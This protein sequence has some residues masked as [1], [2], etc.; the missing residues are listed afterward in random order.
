[1]GNSLPSSRVFPARIGAFRVLP[2]LDRGNRVERQH[3]AVGNRS[4]AAGV[5]RRQLRHHRRPDRIGALAP[6]VGGYLRRRFRR[7]ERRHRGCVRRLTI[8]HQQLAQE[9]VGLS[10][11][12]RCR[13]ERRHAAG[14]QFAG[15]RNAAAHRQQPVHE[16]WFGLDQRRRR[17]HRED[18]DGAGR[19]SHQRHVG[20]IAAEARDVAVDELQRLDDVE[21]RKIAGIVVGISG[22]QLSQVEE[23][24]DAEPV[25]HRDDDRVGGPRQVCA[26]VDRVGRI[27][28]D[29]AAA[30]HPDDHRELRC[31]GGRPPDVHI[32]A[33]LRPD[34]LAQRRADG[35]VVRVVLTRSIEPARLR[36]GIAELLREPRRRPRV[37]I[38][39]RLP[40]QLTHRRLRERHA[41]PG[42]GS[43]RGR[44]I[45]ADHRAE[46]R[47][48]LDR[49]RRSALRRRSDEPFVAQAA[50]GEHEGR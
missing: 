5:D 7:D 3:G 24:H 39:R 6:H 45:A 16:R 42:I 49:W 22:L 41:L 47:L 27:T 43:V 23:A 15:R 20:W 38:G 50:A 4:R 33:I 48:A 11:K 14:R 36:A 8:A 12:R 32:Q 29:V 9:K 18:V 34:R 2:G 19:L 13:R 46:R 37:R 10:A 26:V 40:A 30:V 25:I 31:S 1:M 21:Q 44:Q 17:H 28:R 35:G